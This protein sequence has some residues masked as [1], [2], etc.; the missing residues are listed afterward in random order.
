MLLIKILDFIF[1]FVW[2]LLSNYTFKELE[3]ESSE[4]VTVQ[5]IEECF[6]HERKRHV[7][8]C[9]CVCVCVCVCACVC[10]CVKEIELVYQK[11]SKL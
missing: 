3:R 4:F 6:E 10:V 9:V 8:K 1:Q 5:K 2:D 11:S 7:K